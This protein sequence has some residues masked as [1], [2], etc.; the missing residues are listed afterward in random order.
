MT[1]S[2][3]ELYC[4]IIKIQEINYRIW[5]WFNYD[6]DEQ[7]HQKS[8]LH[9][10]SQENEDR[11][12][13]L[14]IQIT[15]HCKSWNAH[16]NNIWQRYMIQIKILTNINNIERDEDK[17]KYNWTFTNEWSDEMIQSNSETIFKMLYE[18]STKQL[19]RTVI[20]STVC[21]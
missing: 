7:I 21:I 2:Y 9:I 20:S 3:N 5:I 1:I 8:I 18:L 6:C 16:R 13:H 19:N 12:S 4:Q 14:S 15:C 10:I 17:N 11:K